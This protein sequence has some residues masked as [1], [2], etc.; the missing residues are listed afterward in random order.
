[1]KRWSRALRE[2]E[3]DVFKV[4]ENGENC[5]RKNGKKRKEKKEELFEKSSRREAKRERERERRFSCD[6]YARYPCDDAFAL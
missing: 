4:R 5:L 2:R 6:R 1:M 3:R